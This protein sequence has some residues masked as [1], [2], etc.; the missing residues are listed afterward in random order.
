MRFAIIGCGEAGSRRAA[1]IESVEGAQIVV[2]VDSVHDRADAFASRYGAEVSTDWRAAISR[3]D[4]DGVVIATANGTHAGIAIGAAEAGKHILCERPLARNVSEAEQMVAVARE[5]RV[6]LKTGLSARF[7]PVSLKARAIIDSGQLG[8]ITFIRGRTGRGS[9]ITRPAE[10]M[11]NCELAGGGTLIDNGCDLLDLLRY[12]MGEFR[13]AIGHTASLVYN[14][15][16]CEDN[17]FAILETSDGHAAI[18]HSSWTDWRDYMSLDI[19]GSEGYVL[20]DYDNALVRVGYRPGLAGASLE[21]TIDL[22][23]ETD[24][25]FELDVEDLYASVRD[26]REP[27]PSGYDGLEAL[28]LARAIY[29]SSEEGKVVRI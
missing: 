17:A 1:A 21:E 10:W 18:F 25:S 7:H 23:G 27:S 20:L 22:S 12:F 14:I 9:Y 26:D 11:V 24:R 8:K 16:P 2:C 3:V 29:R 15:H 28:L 19:S 13:S 6:K 4:V 5:H